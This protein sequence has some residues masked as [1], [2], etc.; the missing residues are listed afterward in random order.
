MLGC[1]KT[2]TGGAVAG[3]HSLALSGYGTWF[4]RDAHYHAFAES[5]KLYFCPL[6][7][8]TDG[9]QRYLPRGFSYGVR[10]S[11]GFR[12]SSLQ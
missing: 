10:R 9:S 2:G 3:A 7:E 6:Q 4:Q 8:N 5:A 11:R 12:L 1:F